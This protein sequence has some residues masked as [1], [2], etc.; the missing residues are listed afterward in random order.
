MPEKICP[1]CRSLPRA[2]GQAFC[3]ACGNQYARE[4]RQ[5][6]RLARGEQSGR[7]DSQPILSEIPD[8]VRV[9]LVGDGLGWAVVARCDTGGWVPMF[10]SRDK[11]EAILCLGSI[12]G[13]DLRG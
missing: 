8:A 12:F 4:Y 2:K 5:Q 7:I 3:R 9:R 6:K 11:E 1:K 13:R 10:K